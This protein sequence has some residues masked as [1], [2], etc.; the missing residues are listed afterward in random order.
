VAIGDLATMDALKMLQGTTHSQSAGA[1]SYGYGSISPTG[2][3]YSHIVGIT[4]V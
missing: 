2:K 3:A 4:K 1:P